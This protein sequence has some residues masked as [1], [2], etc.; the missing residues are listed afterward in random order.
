[1]PGEMMSPIV[2]LIL[3]CFSASYAVW[4]QCFFWFSLCFSSHKKDLEVKGMLRTSNK[5]DPHKS[6]LTYEICLI[7]KFIPT[8]HRN[9]DTPY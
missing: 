4:F 2:A 7:S 8:I 6:M 9:K 3:F 1:M 5:K